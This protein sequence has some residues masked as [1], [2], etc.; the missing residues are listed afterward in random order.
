[1]GVFEKQIMLPNNDFDAA[2][3]HIRLYAFKAKLPILF[4]WN[5][6]LVFLLIFSANQKD[7]IYLFC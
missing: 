1:M 5:I 7:C 4:S 6:R 3:S 2:S